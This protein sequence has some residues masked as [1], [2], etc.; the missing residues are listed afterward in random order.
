VAQ[1]P[2]MCPNPEKKKFRSKAEA[3]RFHRQFQSTFK[4]R[5]WP[6]ECDTGDHWHLT[7]SPPEEQI[8]I[9]RQI[10]AYLGRLE[11]WQQT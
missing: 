10:D 7:T 5:Q 4:T 2:T 11:E 9:R 3:K 8:R 1:R 6:Y